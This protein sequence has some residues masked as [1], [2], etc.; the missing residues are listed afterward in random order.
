MYI[1]AKG[2]YRTQNVSD[3]LLKEEWCMCNAEL[4]MKED[5]GCIKYFFRVGR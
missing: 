1:C 2:V 4:Y 3:L 5:V